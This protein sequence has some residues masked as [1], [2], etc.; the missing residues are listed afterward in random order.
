MRLAAML[1]EPPV[2]VYVSRMPRSRKL[3]CAKEYS[4]LE[5]PTNTE[6]LLPESRSKTCQDLP[7]ILQRLPRRFEQQALL[8][9]HSRRFAWRNVEER[10]VELIDAFYET[11]PT[12]MALSWFTRFWIVKRAFVPALGRHFADCVHAAS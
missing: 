2:F 3:I 7:A 4:Q 8:R 1:S 5:T 12:G 11:S 6:V 10:R 9:V